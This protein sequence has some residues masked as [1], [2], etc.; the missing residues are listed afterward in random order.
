[1]AQRSV[2]ASE[3]IEGCRGRTFEE[4]IWHHQ[5][6]QDAKARGL[7]RCGLDESLRHPL[8]EHARA[9]A[10]EYRANPDW[11]RR[12]CADVATQFLEQ[13]QDVV[14]NA[15]DD[16]FLDGFTY[17]GLVLADVHPIRGRKFVP[18]YAGILVAALILVN[19]TDA[20]G[21]LIVGWLLTAFAVT[22]LVGA[23]SKPG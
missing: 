19:I 6:G 1:M 16:E 12:D 15:S 3:F 4:F 13:A 8:L 10:A 22:S 18:I 14:F 2:R 17:V 7:N 21:V 9:F 23:L 5:A 20:P 11:L